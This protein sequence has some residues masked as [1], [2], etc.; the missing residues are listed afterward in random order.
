[1]RG[2]TTK[3]ERAD[4][5]L[6]SCIMATGRRQDYLAQ[7]IRYFLRQSYEPRE[8]LVIDDDP[9]SAESIIPKDPRVRY[10]RVDPMTIGRKLNFGIERARGRII[11]K[12]DDDDWYHRWFLSTMVA[13]M[14]A[15]GWEGSMA[16]TST[17]LV[18]ILETGELKHGGHTLFVGGSLA[19]DRKLWEKAPFEDLS[20]GEDDRF[21][22][23]HVGAPRRY[24]IDPELYV[25]VRRGEGHTW[26]M[27]GGRNIDEHFKRQ[28]R[29]TKSLE[30]IV[31]AEDAA[32]YRMKIEARQRAIG[33]LVER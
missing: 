7:A 14:S 12:L 2:F 9:D 24:L 5:P 25:V 33:K 26:T 3:V 28:P 22:A 17:F 31:G 8:L 23:A 13:T 16:S 18:L 11:Q 4:G 27:A 15:K 19:F 32:F 21:I 10:Y 20:D 1:M 29:Y 30:E 6:V